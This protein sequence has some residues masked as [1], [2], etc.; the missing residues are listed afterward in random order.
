MPRLVPLKPREVE[1][2]LLARGN[3]RAYDGI[4][5][6][7]RNPPWDASKYHQAVTTAYRPVPKIRYSFAKLRVTPARGI[8]RFRYR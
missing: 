2:I 5:S 7:Q 6:L 3:G 4:L 8:G 1:R